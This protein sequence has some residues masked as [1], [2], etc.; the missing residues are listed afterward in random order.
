MRQERTPK[1]NSGVTTPALLGLAWDAKDGH[2]RL[3]RG[4][5]FVLAGGS[6]ETHSQMQE[7]VIKVNEKLTTR[8]K[9]F[10]SASPEE[11]RD[12]FGEATS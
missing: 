4:T 8:G 5:D 1:N 10:R 2:K 3:T 6:D 9:S 7:T 11:L 12:L